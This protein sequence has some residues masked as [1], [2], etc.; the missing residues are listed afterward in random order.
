MT[1]SEKQASAPPQVNLWV[2]FLI[3]LITCLFGFLAEG[4]IFHRLWAT[5]VLTLIGALYFAAKMRRFKPPVPYKPFFGE[6][7]L[8]GA[9]N[10]LYP[11]SV[12]LMWLAGYFILYWL[13]YIVRWLLLFPFPAIDWN[14]QVTGFWITFILAGL[15]HLIFLWADVFP[16]PPTN[17]K[18][19]P[20]VAGL[21]SE[22]YPVYTRQQKTFIAVIAILAV[23]II[24]PTVLFLIFG[25]NFA[26]LYI[27][28]ALF[29]WLVS[30]LA[31]TPT[32][33]VP[34]TA[35]ETIAAVGELL[36]AAGYRNLKS[37][38][39]RR[40]PRWTPCSWRW[41]TLPTSPANFMPSM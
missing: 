29:V 34:Q 19:F 18:L 4:L 15:L 3:G 25:W 13:F 40:T 10:M 39:A 41:I 5:G 27:W 22:Y 2:F 31:I 36:K 20:S 23:I 11:A 14:I 37:P 33:T 9:E 30:A 12:G 32:I 8:Y 1:D 24:V 26:I 38:R 21:R 6:Y 7:L 35:Q 16:D 17:G 28:L